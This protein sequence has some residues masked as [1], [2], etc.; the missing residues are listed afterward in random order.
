MMVDGI[1]TP[2]KL[3]PRALHSQLIEARIDKHRLTLKLQRRQILFTQH[4][5]PCDN[6]WSPISNKLKDWT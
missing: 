5:Q 1:C 2:C 6:L 4:T 3:Q